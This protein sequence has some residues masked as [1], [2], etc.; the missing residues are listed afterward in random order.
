MTTIQARNLT[1]DDVARLLKF[2]A[3]YDGSFA[4]LLTLEPVSEAE[5][6]ELVQIRNDFRPYITAGQ[7]LEGQ[8]RLLAIAPFLRLAGFYRP[9]IQL[10]VEE[11]IARINIEDEDLLITGR[12]DIIAVNKNPHT[13]TN[14][15]FWILAI[16][17]KKGTVDPIAGIPQLLTYAYNSLASQ[18]SVWGLATNGVRYQFVYVQAGNPPTYQYMPI[19]NLL[20]T[21][22]AIKLLQVLKAI[23]K[24]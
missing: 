3:R 2:E 21:E 1:L 14:I 6:Q 22:G 19:L 10:K 7:P 12:F 15:D 5:Q 16:E 11:D 18:E 17:T 24:L 20:E 9:P 23:C 8:V 4:P 13:P